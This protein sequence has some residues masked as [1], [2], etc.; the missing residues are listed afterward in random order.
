MKTFLMAAV[1]ALHSIE[2]K[3]NNETHIF[4]E[5]LVPHIK[6]ISVALVRKRAIPPE[7][8]PHVGEVNIN[9]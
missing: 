7:R 6:I 2:S 4:L 9:L 5:S 3:R 8:P 1:V